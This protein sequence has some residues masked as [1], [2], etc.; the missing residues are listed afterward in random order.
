MAL[1]INLVSSR[2]F[3]EFP[4]K[5]ASACGR[6]SIDPFKKRSMIFLLG[7]IKL[8]LPG[9]IFQKRAIEGPGMCEIW[10][11]VSPDPSG[12]RWVQ[13]GLFQ[14]ILVFEQDEELEGR[15]RVGEELVAGGDKVHA[16]AAG[17]VGHLMITV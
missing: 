17:L 3:A 12:R 7:S 13:L 5:F 4:R 10:G 15:K 1:G 8:V 6:N 11:G 2:K 16:V 9:R 14:Q